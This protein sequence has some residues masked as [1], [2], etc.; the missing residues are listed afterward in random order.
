MKIIKENIENLDRVKGL[1]PVENPVMADAQQ[2]SEKK[3]KETDELMNPLE[4]KKK[5]PFI[6][7]EK[8]ET[9]K[10]PEEAKATLEESLFEDVDEDSNFFDVIAVIDSD[11]NIVDQGFNSVEEAKKYADKYSDYSVAIVTFYTEDDKSFEVID[12]KPI[13]ESL[14][15]DFNP[16]NLTEEQLWKLRNEIRLG[17]L[18]TRDY[19]NSFGI[20]E[21]N[22][23]SF[24]DG[25]LEEL[26]YK[27]EEDGI[28]DSDFWKHVSEYDNA[29]NLW[30]WYCSV[31]YPFG[32]YV[33][34]EDDLDE[35]WSHFQFKSGSNPYIALNDEERD[36]IL[37]K[38][39]EKVTE[40]KPGFYEVDD[41]EEDK[42][43][44]EESLNEG[45]S[46]QELIDAVQDAY[47]YNKTQALKYIKTLSDD[48]KKELVQ[49]FKNN[50]KKS[51]LTDSLNESSDLPLW[52]GVKDV[53]YIW[54]GSW[55]DPELEYN[56]YTFN[57]WDIEDALWENFLED[58]GHVD[59][60]SDDPEVEE[61]FNEYLKGTAVPYLE[62]VIA[63]GYFQN[64]SKHWTGKDV[65]ES[66][67]EDKLSNYSNKKSNLDK[68]NEK[69]VFDKVYRE[70]SP[71]HT[72][73]YKKNTAFKD[74][75]MDKRY[76]GDLTEI[77]NDGNIVVYG[78]DEDALSFAKQ[79]ADKFNCKTSIMKSANYKVK[80]NPN[81]AY[82]MTIK[83]EE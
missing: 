7:A 23:F 22:C 75:G 47:G 8:Q 9:P 49:G 52:R 50:A 18:F 6:G 79:V 64:G 24:F 1:T 11:S 77:D 36:R 28:S 5:K 63:G 59:S 39:G 19:R 65:D 40:L 73:N 46:N 74:V 2:Y 58:T 10:E 14:S 60:D 25:Y 62:D 29:E 76:S 67:N 61:E 55:S 80:Q 34:T 56:G 83:V 31:E 54:N 70:L 3:S 43:S 48:A 78:K 15:E 26:G 66:L 68:Q 33:G 4:L 20:P 57:Y 35:S 12:I 38:Y 16:N 72:G 53:Y 82:K 44:V 42:F 71:D 45:Y 37:T 81:Y 13:N 27:M 17:S 30:D 32:D 21:E 69:T 51:F 41:T